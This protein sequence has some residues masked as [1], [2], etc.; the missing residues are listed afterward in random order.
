MCMLHEA[1]LPCSQSWKDTWVYYRVK[2]LHLYSIKNNRKTTMAISM[3]SWIIIIKQKKHKRFNFK[4]FLTFSHLEL[5]T[6]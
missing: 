3:A 4:R 6:I 1:S 2:K 5:N